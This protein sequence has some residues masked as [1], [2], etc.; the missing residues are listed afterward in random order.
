MRSNTKFLAA[1][2]LAFT[3]SPAFAQSQTPVQ[4]GGWR[5]FGDGDGA[6]SQAQNQPPQ[7]Q[8][9]QSAARPPQ[10][11][12]P[13]F[14]DRQD[15]PPPS[16][17]PAPARLTIPAGTWITVR[18][19]QPISSAHNR[20]GDAFTAT[21]TSPIVAN[22]I[23]VARR[24]QTLAGRVAE[25]L[26][27][28]RIKGTSSLGVELIELSIVDGQRIPVRTELMLY[29]GG[30]SVGRDATAIA[31]TTGLGAA[32]GASA[33]GGFGAGMGAIAGAGAS[34]IGVL[35]TRGR[36]TE[37]YPETAITFRL[38]APVEIST[39][40]SQQAFHAVRQEDFE[41]RQLQQ[42]TVHV[43]APPSYYG[44]GYGSGYGYGYG[45]P[46]FYS[47]YRS[48]GPSFYFSTGHRGYGG[49]GFRR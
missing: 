32:I 40:R 27:A 31:T 14:D 34:A 16:Y 19:D 1:V 7:N 29:A 6:V 10:T 49:R 2:A 28:G 44:A 42:R 41:T 47:P 21:L 12:R 43:S 4:D 45:Y 20:A 36:A 5:K 13:Q 48:F 25:S 46:Y 33:A 26:K 9:D 24:G 15:F 37:I 17:Q 11:A 38:T 8:D 22:G 30:T 18:V 39:E 3:I 23:V 35:T